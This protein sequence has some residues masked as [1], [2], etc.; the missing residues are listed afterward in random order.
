MAKQ[1]LFKI[2]TAD[3]SEEGYAQGLQ[4]AKQHQPNSK[5]Q[6]LKIISP[7]NYLWRFEHAYDSFTEYYNHGYLDGQRVNN[8]IYQP[9]TPTQGSTM[10][11][12]DNYDN[13]L[14]ML[15]EA[16]TVLASLKR[17]LFEIEAKYKRQI[18]AAEG[19]G[20][21]QN[22]T[23]P[24]KEK[25]QRFAAKVEHLTAMIEQHTSRIDQQEQVIHSLKSLAQHY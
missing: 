3:Y 21:V 18:E 16:K 13:H 10:A 5:F 2:Y 11:V 8:T 23:D 14:R 6:V 17:Y 20:F 25:Q 7:L 19:A 4:D 12:V 24:L 9:S 22:Y 15:E 1:G